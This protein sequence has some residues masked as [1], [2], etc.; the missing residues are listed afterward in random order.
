MPVSDLTLYDIGRQIGRRIW[1]PL[2]QVA[3]V[4]HP[5]PVLSALCF[6]LLFALTGQLHEIYFSS[7]EPPF[8]SGKAIQIALALASL[9]LASAA[10]FFANYTLSTTKIDIIYSDS[11]NHETDMRLRAVRNATG[12]IAALLPWAGLTVGLHTA[13]ERAGKNVDQL[14]QATA[15][16]A[17]G[18]ADIDNASAL[19][20][21]LERRLLGAATVALLVGV[22]IATLLH[23]Y[24]RDRLLRGS[25]L[26][27]AATMFAGLLILPALLPAS[28]MDGSGRAFI[29]II[30]GVSLFRSPGPMTMVVLVA[31]C[32]FSVLAVLSLLSGQIGFPILALA[33]VM[34]ITA[35]LLQLPIHWIVRSAIVVFS[36]VAILGLLSRHVAL[37]ALAVILVLF[38]YATARQLEGSGAAKISP[39]HTGAPPSTAS[40]ALKDSFKAWVDARRDEIAAYESVRRKKFPVFIVSAQGGGIY[41]AAAAGSFLARLQD[42]CPRFANHLFA[43]SGVSGGAVGAAVFE[44]MLKASRTDRAECSSVAAASPDSLSSKT[45]AVVL[46]DHLSPL[47]GT[48][49]ADLLGLHPDRALALEDSFIRSMRARG[50]R[51]LEAPF[52]QHW[53]AR[54]AAPALLLNATWVETGYRVA[55]A[56]FSLG[57]MRDGTLYAF[58]DPKLASGPG[59]NLSLAGAA[60]VSARFPGVV[61]AFS[62]MRRGVGGDKS[63]IQRWNFVDGGYADGSG[64]AT[65]LEIY[66]ALQESGLAGS[67]DLRLVLLTSARPEP[68]F[69]RIEGTIARD[70]LTPALTLFSVRD[71]L[72]KQAVMRTISEVETNAGAAALQ[73]KEGPAQLGE[74]DGWKA[75]VIELDH[76]SFTLALGW[77]ISTATYKLVSLL[78][79]RPELC[80]PRGSSRAGEAADAEQ[81]ED[82]GHQLQISTKTIRANSCVMRAISEMVVPTR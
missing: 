78:M 40:T 52:D 75:T 53:D 17:A 47:L 38:S 55:F 41:A 20:G 70:V 21:M 67:V 61:P 37:T 74:T 80:P 9:A 58:G 65:A 39:S 19:F 64:A 25:I 50:A 34:V 2:R 63:S 12:F 79:G 13:A 27:L 66:K 77:K 22:A 56:P 68:D 36:V 73:N 23:W 51:A 44:G 32:L 81:E 33:L 57:G 29:R 42:H 16:L 45:S 54:A 5:V 3:Q 14:D 28:A 35:V 7:L 4:V 71:L 62:F 1:R 11:A 48:L 43:I 10:L 26:T 6:G 15:P 31:L 8:D 69:D 76:E 49:L 30:D 82:K 59:G 46:D 24:R 18:L 72:A 60:I